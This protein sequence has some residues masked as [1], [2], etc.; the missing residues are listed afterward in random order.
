MNGFGNI[1]AVIL[2]TNAKSSISTLKVS[3]SLSQWVGGWLTPE[4][5]LDYATVV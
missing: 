2:V 5:H 4:H 1:Y 3:F